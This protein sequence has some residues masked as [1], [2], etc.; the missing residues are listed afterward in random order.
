MAFELGRGAEQGDLHIDSP[1]ALE[2]EHSAEGQ[3]EEALEGEQGAERIRE[4]RAEVEQG[5]DNLAQVLIETG[6]TIDELQGLKQS[7]E[8]LVA[9]AD[10]KD[11][12]TMGGKVTKIFETHFG[13]KKETVYRGVK[14]LGGIGIFL[15][16]GETIYHGYKAA[17]EHGTPEGKAHLKD[18]YKAFVQAFPPAL[19][20]ELLYRSGR[21]VV[22]DQAER[23]AQKAEI[24]QSIREVSPAWMWVSGNKE[25]KKELLDTGKSMAIMTADFFTLGTAA[26][27]GISI[28]TL[29][30]AKDAYAVS[31]MF[32]S[33]IDKLEQRVASGEDVTIWDLSGE[34]IQ[35]SME[36]TGKSSAEVLDMLG[37][38]LQNT[39]FLEKLPEDQRQRMELIAKILQDEEGRQEVLRRVE[40]FDQYLQAKKQK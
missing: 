27:A 7:F 9:E 37:T 33:R 30:L 20:P 40:Q 2:V 35:A 38:T 4:G 34:F 23:V 29:Y 19:V 26:T 32:T 17:V 28:E 1:E 39:E 24:S 16:L 18:S 13:A 36:A 3:V 31:K 6:M 10:L 22:G 15:N 21:Y 11:K 8:Q 5:R 14:A 12:D 25:Q